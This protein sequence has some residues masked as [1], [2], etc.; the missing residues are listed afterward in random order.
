MLEAMA[1]SL[2]VVCSAIRGNVDVVRDG[3]NGYLFKPSDVDTLSRKIAL[4]MDNEA[5]RLQMGAKNKKIVRE[6]SLEAVTE[7]L[8]AIYSKVLYDSE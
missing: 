2:P 6:F 4:L 1:C 5:L 8:K 7:E 3:D